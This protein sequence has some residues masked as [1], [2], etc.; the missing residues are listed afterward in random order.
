MT[1]CNFLVYFVLK[2]ASRLFEIVVGEAPDLSLGGRNSLLPFFFDFKGSHTL[3]NNY[4]HFFS[5]N[6][7][8]ITRLVL[9]AALAAK[10]LY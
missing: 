3:L 8:C 1:V 10:C 7:L 4:T 6:V 5:P 2:F 9:H